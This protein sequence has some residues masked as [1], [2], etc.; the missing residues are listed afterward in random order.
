LQRS[1]EANMKFLCLA[2]G[3]EEDWKK[4]SSEEQKTLLAQDQLLRDRGAIMSAVELTVTMV[5]AWDGVPTT[6]A[7]PFAVSRVPL[8]GFSVIEAE[9]MDDA[10]QLVAHTPCARA[11]GAVEIRPLL[12][13][14]EPEPR[15]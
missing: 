11:G 1:E 13:T 6:K 9:N 15:R 10:V 4:V 7:E 14:G 3:S 8:A 2:Y 5:T 12:R